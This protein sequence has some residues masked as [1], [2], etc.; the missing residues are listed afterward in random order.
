MYFVS[1]PSSTF[2]TK[3][4]AIFNHISLEFH[5]YLRSPFYDFDI[6]RLDN[7][8]TSSLIPRRANLG[9]L[10]LFFVWQSEASDYCAEDAADFGAEAAALSCLKEAQVLLCYSFLHF[11]SIWVLH[12][13]R[14]HLNNDVVATNFAPIACKLRKFRIY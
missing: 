5:I 12:F 4:F 2:S 13:H 7:F 6:S 1:E 3:L 9:S 14:C 10:D 8:A 11:W